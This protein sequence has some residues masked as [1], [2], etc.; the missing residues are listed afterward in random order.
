[1]KVGDVSHSNK[2][3]SLTAQNPIR[4]KVENLTS[5]VYNMSIQKQENNRPFKPKRGH[6]RHKFSNRYRNR[7]FSRDTQ[8]QN[9]RPNYRGQSHNRCMQHGNDSRRGSYRHQND[10]RNNSRDRGRQNLQEK[11]Q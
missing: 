4:E 2:Q 5:T 10:D 3:V 1:M 7:S 6:K 11:L 9:F 8:R